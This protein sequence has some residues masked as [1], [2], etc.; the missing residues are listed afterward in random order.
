MPL[1]LTHGWAGHGRGVPRPCGAVSDP[2]RFDLDPVIAFDLV[3]P[4]LPGCGWSGPT[5]DRRL[6]AAPDRPRLGAS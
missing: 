2:R 5:P 1:L 3:I 4:S 6:G